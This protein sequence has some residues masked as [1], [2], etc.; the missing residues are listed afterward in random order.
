MTW[1]EF[2]AWV[3]ERLKELGVENPEIQ[4]IDFSSAP[5][6]L[7]IDAQMRWMSIS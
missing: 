2:K 3:E 6:E 4:Y 1:E 5:N 7:G